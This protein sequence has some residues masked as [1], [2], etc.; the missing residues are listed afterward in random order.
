MFVPE[1]APE[2]VFAG[3]SNEL[4]LGQYRAENKPVIDALRS[5]DRAGKYYL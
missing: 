4:P 1:R 3:S 2:W 5:F